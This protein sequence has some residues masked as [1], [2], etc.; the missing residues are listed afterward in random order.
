MRRSQ[1]SNSGTL[2]HRALSALKTAC[3]RFVALKTKHQ[4]LERYS[5]EKLDLFN[6]YQ[7]T[8]SPAR[9]FAVILL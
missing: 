9:V 5:I 6:Q 7:Q 8:A 1:A 4:Y 2:R 3:H